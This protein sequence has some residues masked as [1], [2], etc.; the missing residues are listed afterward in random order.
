MRKKAIVFLIC[1]AIVLTFSPAAAAGE[2]SGF[3]NMGEAP[4]VG[5]RALTAAGETAPAQGLTLW[6]TEYD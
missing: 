6:E 5:I 1:A 3:F 2:D 4:G